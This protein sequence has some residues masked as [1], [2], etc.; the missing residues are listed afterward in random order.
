MKELCGVCREVIVDS[1]CAEFLDEHI[2]CCSSACAQAAFLGIAL[3]DIVR[4]LARIGT[5]IY[6][7]PRQ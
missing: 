3:R 6:D 1:H 5:A 7:A 2:C 4:N